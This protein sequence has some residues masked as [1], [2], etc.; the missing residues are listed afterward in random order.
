VL[1]TYLD[2]LQ[3]DSPTTLLFLYYLP[4]TLENL[5]RLAH[6]HRK[7]DKLR[8]AWVA[9]LVKHLTLGFGSGHHLMGRGIKIEP[10]IGLSVEPA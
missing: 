3:N 9:K 7:N 5:K 10:Y 1:N 4:L 6:K 2:K 8:G